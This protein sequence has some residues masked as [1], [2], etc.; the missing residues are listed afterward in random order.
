MLD[1]FIKQLNPSA[2]VIK[3]LLATNGDMG[4]LRPF[5]DSDDD[6]MNPNAKSYV[7][8]RNTSTGKYENILA[9]N[10]EA[11][12]RKDEWI[13]MDRQLIQTAKERLNLVADFRAAGLQF[14]IPNG[15]G[16][17]ILESENIGDVNDAIESM[18]G[19]REG[20]NDRQT[21]DIVGVPL[22]IT[23]KD[24][25]FSLRTILTSR[26]S[27][28]PIDT[29][30]VS[31]TT[32][33]VSER[34]ERRATGVTD[35]YTYGAYTIQGL[36]SYDN[37][38]TR[39]LTSPTAS[40]WT[41]VTTL[42]EV[43]QMRQDSQ[44]I[45]YFGPWML[46]TSPN[47]DAYLDRDYSSQYPGVTLRSRIKEVNNIQDVKTLDFLTGF[48][49]VLI[50]MTSDVFRIVVGMEMVVV[51]WETHGGMKQNYKVMTIQVPQPRA[52]QNLSTGIVHGSTV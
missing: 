50:Q 40:G 39:V 1:Q 33:K 23:H 20:E 45:F 37:R 15:M 11:T 16:K 27:G 29:S 9:N 22:P 32:R 31:V 26:N 18:D 12:L 42:N 36:T 34:V 4:C 41:P 3:R 8:I 28:T 21:Y 25:H 46:Y 44:D 6:P 7:S 47:W 43:I 52:D 10:V 30:A 48:D 2:S 38:I 49:M 17:T 13:E 19:L 35:D 24:F 51:N 5:L 14:V